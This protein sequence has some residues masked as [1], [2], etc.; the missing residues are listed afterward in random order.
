MLSTENSLIPSSSCLGLWVNLVSAYGG[1]YRQPRETPSYLSLSGL[2][3]SPSG[4]ERQD[5]R[6]EKGPV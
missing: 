4:G 1:H 6:A 5:P 3:R 2:W